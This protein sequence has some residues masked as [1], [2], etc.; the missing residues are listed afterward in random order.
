MYGSK[1][2]A[3]YFDNICDGLSTEAV[4]DVFKG[5]KEEHVGKMAAWLSIA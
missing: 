4:H 3:V 5:R 2:L 1:E